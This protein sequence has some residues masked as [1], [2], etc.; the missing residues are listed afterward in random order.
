MYSI[1]IYIYHGHIRMCKHPLTMNDCIDTC[2]FSYMYAYIN[3][4]MN[5][6]LNMRMHACTCMQILYAYVH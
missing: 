6:H 2:I 1:Y 4:Y 3:T 5:M